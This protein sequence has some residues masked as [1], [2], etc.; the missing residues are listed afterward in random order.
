MISR[1]LDTDEDDDRVKGQLT[2]ILENLAAEMED[3]PS[4]GE[5]F[6]NSTKSRNLQRVLLGMGP[7]LFN[8]WS[9][10]NVLCC[11]SHSLSYTQCR[12]NCCTLKTP[13]NV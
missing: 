1:L 6:S 5:V 7:Y 9:G 8:Q 11:R 3:E 2:E 4:W 10:I 12:K 13:A